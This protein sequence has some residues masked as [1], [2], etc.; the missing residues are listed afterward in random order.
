[1]RLDSSIQGPL[2]LNVGRLLRAQRRLWHGHHIIERLD[3]GT[4]LRPRELRSLGAFG[5]LVALRRRPASVRVTGGSNG[6][7]ILDGYVGLL[8][9]A[10]S[11]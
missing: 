11:S 6:H 2:S 5:L 8:Y 4:S 1:M 10:R 3:Q 7:R 9:S